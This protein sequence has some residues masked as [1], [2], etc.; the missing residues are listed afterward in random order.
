ML[1]AG[2]RRCFGIGRAAAVKR[3]CG[4]RIEPDRLVE[5][6]NGTIEVALAIEGGA[7][8]VEG[9]GVFR[10]APDRL[11][12]IGDGTREVALGLVGDATVVERLGVIRIEPDRNALGGPP[13]SRLQEEGGGRGRNEGRSI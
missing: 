5:I 13:L 8:V 11:I 4:F 6:G 10:I 12:E 7:A 1:M 9:I 2:F 3:C